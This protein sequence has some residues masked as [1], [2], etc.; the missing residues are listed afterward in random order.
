MIEMDQIIGILERGTLVT[1]Y[2]HRKKAERTLAIKR[3]T[4]QIV[5]SKKT[6][7]SLKCNEGFLNMEEIKEIRLGKNSK[8]FEKWSE[9]VKKVE[10]FQ[11]F[12]IYY[13][14][15]FKLKVLSIVAFSEEECELWIKGLR[16]LVK[17]TSN[18]YLI[19]TQSW[20]R[21]EF[22][23]ME[24]QKEM[25]N[26]KDLKLFFPKINYKMP[27]VKLRE[28]FNDV[29]SRKRSEI[30]FDDFEKLY[31]KVIL[32][33]DILEVMMDTLKKYSSD[34]KTV[35]LLDLVAFLQN[36]QSEMNE[37]ERNVSK[38]MRDFLGDPQRNV[39]DPFFEMEEFFDYLFSKQ[40]EVWNPDMDKVYQDMSKPLS[41]YWI[42]SSHNT[43]LTGDQLS[44]ESS[45]E[46]Y[47]RC[48]RMGCRCIELDCW[49]GPDGMP[50]I[51]HGHTLTTKIKFLDVIKT[52]KE[53]AFTTSE[54]PVILSIEDNCSLPQQRKMASALQEVFGEMLL[55]QP[56][57][58]YENKLPSPY[59]L[60][61]KIILK[62]KKLPEGEEEML[63]KNEGNEMDLR[64]SVKNGIMYI[65]DPVDKE[66]NPHF[67]VLTNSK[68]FYTDSYHM[69]NETS[70]S[71]RGAGSD[72]ED[73]QT[74]SN[75]A[76]SAVNKELHFGEK[77]FHGRLA[78]GPEEAKQLLKSYAHLGDG[79]FLVRA[80]VTFVGEYCLSFWR[81]GQVHHCRIRSKQDKQQTKY[82]LMDTKF[83]D[84]LYSL[85]TYY[86][87]CPLVTAEFAITL[88]EP[89][90]Q[91]RKHETEKWYHKTTGKIQAE[92]VLKRVKVEGAFLVRPSENDLNCYTI[93]FRADRKI[94]HCRIKLE[95]R[96]YTIGNVE[97]ESLIEL[98]N[99]YQN[100]PLYKKVKLTQAVS[101]E[102]IGRMPN[103]DLTES[104]PPT[105]YHPSMYVDPS[106]LAASRVTVKAQFDYRA[107]R[108]D[109]LSFCKHAIIT[110]VIKPNNIPGWWRGDYGG[111]KQL[112]FPA[113][114]VKEI[115][116]TEQSVDESLNGESM[117]HGQLDMN[118]AVVDFVE[119]PDRVGL[120]CTLRIVTST[121]CTPF[122]VALHSRELAIEW[123][124]QIR[125]VAQRACHLETQHRKM[126]KACRIAKEMSNMIIYCRSIAFNLEKAKLSNFVFNEMSSF[127][128]NKGIALMCQQERRFFLKY[129]Q[130]QFSRVYPKGQ[131]IDSSNYNPINLWNVGSQMVALNYQ[132]GDKPMQINQA[133]FRENGQCGYILKPACMEQEN[134][135]PFDKNTLNGVNSLKVTIQVIAARHLN[136]SKKGIGSPF[137]EIEVLGA[138]FDSG[139][140]LTTKAAI[141]NGLNPVWSNESCEF[142]VYNPYLALVRFLVQEEDMFGEPNFLGQSTYPL[143]CLRTGYRSVWLKN[144]FSEDSEL[145]S[146][147]I[148]LKIDK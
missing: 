104:P 128:E 61:R 125:E 44:S 55:T 49:D 2:C 146:L 33:G 19:Q 53:H 25:I 133:K 147:L 145:S 32:D 81:Q 36:E 116:S 142:I 130:H 96:L 37:D 108:G 110:N 29:D 126:E 129:H 121:A 103:M 91:P 57:D 122:Q 101:Q 10:N 135:D 40:N 48:L 83:F 72:D 35:P 87:Q 31:Q 66:W 90:P 77:W 51:Y 43:Y 113:N 78:N 143:L 107:Q 23:L 8:D 15:E 85:I 65:E 63:I 111:M 79:T 4:R 11:C 21:R 82:F 27:T 94:K 112:Y 98:V 46:A 42:A 5:W 18:A 138:P 139:V 118:G 93:S 95:G 80:S 92:A 132:T 71:E 106:A 119:C 6:N 20:L 134:F 89:V 127:P 59:Q 120:E 69:D 114:Y 88:K 45:V 75:Q 14:T 68:L 124:L 74:C 28:I 12:V 140:K 86:R 109:E 47:V 3:E 67:F 16:Y 73:V 17:D 70:E 24:G 137:I 30:C 56:V 148:H 105:M 39:L 115:D 41:H 64:N 99:Y 76:S 84:S 123:L 7:N 54:Y 102:I 9:D 34:L 58:K 38:F 1:K 52:I 131:R 50:F 26:L 22:Y 117:L 100:H 13:G 60:R 136:R 141:D 97:F 62:H 144:S